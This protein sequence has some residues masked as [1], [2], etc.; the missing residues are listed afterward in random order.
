MQ[1]RLESGWGALF[2]TVVVCGLAVSGLSL[3]QWRG[4]TALALLS[5]AAM[6]FH[7][8]LRHFILLPSVLA[9]TSGLML[10]ISGSGGW[11]IMP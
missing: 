11:Q 2:A 10:M 9:L 8:R 5:T 4:M 1:K 7:S 6:L 3:S